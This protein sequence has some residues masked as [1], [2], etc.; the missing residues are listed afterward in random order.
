[1]KKQILIADDDIKIT[2]A[3]A[4]RLRANDYDVLVA[5]DGFTALKLAVLES[6][7]L[8]I[9]DMWMPV[10]IGL[11]VAE[12]LQ[13]RGIQVPI[14]FL[15]GCRDE[16]VRVAANSVGAA[17]YLEKPYDPE[18]LLATIQRLCIA[19]PETVNP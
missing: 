7:D 5:N 2:T 6:P 17:A 8:M 12:R 3:L 14:V 16:K 13:E 19:A 9:L 11:S 1:M 10:G 4:A 18:E 15:T